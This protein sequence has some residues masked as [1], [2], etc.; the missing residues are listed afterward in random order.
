MALWYEFSD[1]AVL[2][3]KKIPPRQIILDTWEY[4]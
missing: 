4:N 3:K 2:A 1:K